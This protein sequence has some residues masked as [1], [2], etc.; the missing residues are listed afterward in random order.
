MAVAGFQA[1]PD[2]VQETDLKKNIKN[3][4]N[5]CFNYYKT[6]LKL[7]W[8]S[9]LEAIISYTNRNMDIIFTPN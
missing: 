4:Q 5:M 1:R 8:T 7:D 3:I 9:T 6:G 2:I